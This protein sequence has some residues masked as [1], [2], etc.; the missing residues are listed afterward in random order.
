MELFCARQR[1][2]FSRGIKRAC[3]GGTKRTAEALVSEYHLVSESESFGF[4][5]CGSRPVTVLKKLRKVSMGCGTWLRRLESSLKVL[6]D[7]TSSIATNL[8]IVFA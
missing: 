6:K 2:K 5:C 1:R 3:P 7:S 4:I 8:S